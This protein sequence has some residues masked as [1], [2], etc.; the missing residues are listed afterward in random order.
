MKVDDSKID[1]RPDAPPL[2][3]NDVESDSESIDFDRTAR[4]SREEVE[5]SIREPEEA[6]AP[7][8]FDPPENF[9]GAIASFNARHVIL[10]RALRAEIGA[11]A[12]NFVR[13]CRGTLDSRFA[14]MFE[15]AELRADGSWDPDGLKRSVIAH[16]VENAPD[17]FQKLLDDELQRLRVHLGEARAAALADQLSTILSTAR[18][19]V[20]GS[21][22]SSAP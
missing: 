1:M 21:S 13:S 8:P 4:V 9:D 20:Y 15:T 18:P 22:S 5:A 17:G 6:P 19:P 11:G 2:D 16:R 12:A 10:F 14:S 3:R 7:L